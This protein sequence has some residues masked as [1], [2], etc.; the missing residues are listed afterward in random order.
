MASDVFICYANEDEETAG[1]ICT[2]FENND[3]SCW[4]KSRDLADKNDVYEIL[5]AVRSSKSLFF[6]HSINA[7]DCNYVSSEIDIAFSENI[8]I[9]VFALDKSEMGGKIGF[10]LKDKPQITGA[11]PDEKYSNALKDISIILNRDLD[12][13]IILDEAQTVSNKVFI[14]YAD[15]DEKIADG[16]CHNLEKN[17]IKCWIKN[18]DL[19]IKDTSYS[20]KENLESS[21]AVVMIYSRDSE[22]SSYIKTETD[23]AIKKNIPIIIYNVDESDI[24]LKLGNY[25]NA[26]ILNA[27]PNISSELEDLVKRT[28]IILNQ[29]IDDVSVKNIDY[30]KKEIIIRTPV[31]N[32]K[33]P[34][35]KRRSTLR[36]IGIVFGLFILWI[37]I[38]II[39]IFVCF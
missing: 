3:I 5:K 12:Q 36:T 25:S 27:Y 9:L 17:S 21:A 26:Q 19:K 34:P 39:A 24:N 38:G 18:R 28:S 23:L 7:E 6:I 32:K 8:P 14:S 1:D 30:Q 13:D 2:L 10:Y 37:I 35:K 11:S 31:K 33:E 22:R 16:I 15:E 20:I 4:F 29:P